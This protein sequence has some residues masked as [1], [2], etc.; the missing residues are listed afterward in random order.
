[1]KIIPQ[2]LLWN[3]SFYTNSQGKYRKKFTTAET[4]RHI[5]HWYAAASCVWL[6]DWFFLCWK[7]KCLFNCFSSLNKKSSA[8]FFSFSFFFFLYCGEVL[9]GTQ[10]RQ[11]RPEERWS[12]LRESGRTQPS[13]KDYSS[14]LS[15]P[16]H[17]LIAMW[18]KNMDMGP[19][20]RWN[21]Q[22][23]TESE[24]KL[25]RSEGGIGG[26]RRV[27]GCHRMKRGSCSSD[28]SWEASCKVD[29]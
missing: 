6:T 19:C 22:L 1:M 13:D 9:W 18:I 3:S 14:G 28:A 16:A 20:N 23:Q 2:Q 24:V 21:I 26:G 17:Y 25:D 10:E 7:K 27:M 8:D 4:R 11:S 12:R 15:G 5:L 29:K